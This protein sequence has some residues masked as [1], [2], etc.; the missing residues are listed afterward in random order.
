VRG[1]YSRTH[2]LEKTTHQL[3]CWYFLFQGRNN[4]RGTK[5]RV[6]LGLG[7][8][9]K[10]LQHWKFVAKPKSKLWWVSQHPPS[11]LLKIIIGEGWGWEYNL[12]N[13]LESEWD[14][15]LT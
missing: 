6:I 9:P 12:H 5:S 2:V 4:Q 15:N 1:L 10:A 14:H 7:F 3:L 11:L 8:P 13:P